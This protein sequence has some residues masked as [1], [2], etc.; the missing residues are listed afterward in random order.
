M[1]WFIRCKNR[2]CGILISIDEINLKKIIDNKFDG[3]VEYRL[4][5]KREHI[6]QKNNVKIEK[7]NVQTK[8]DIL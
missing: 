6:F 1:G 2:K 4:V 8:T 3:T 7:S 5:F